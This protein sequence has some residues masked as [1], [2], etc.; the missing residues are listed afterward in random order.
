M[1]IV[2]VEQAVVTE[3]GGAYFLGGS[4]PDIP[5]GGRWTIRVAKATPF[6]GFL[7]WAE[8]DPS[9]AVV[10]TESAED[11][12][13]FV[14]SKDHRNTLAQARDRAGQLATVLRGTA[15]EFNWRREASRLDTRILTPID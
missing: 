15:E 7:I 6:K 4:P 10:P 1:T 12:M 14:A 8:H 11:G 9:G 2:V 13:S 3:H 5:S